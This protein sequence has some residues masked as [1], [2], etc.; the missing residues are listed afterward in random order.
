MSSDEERRAAGMRTRR[1]VLGRIP[2]GLRRMAGIRTQTRERL[3]EPAA[4]PRGALL[5]EFA[6]FAAG[7]WLYL[8]ARAARS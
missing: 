1:E 3:T 4:A 7:P 5:R 6:G 2:L 8:R